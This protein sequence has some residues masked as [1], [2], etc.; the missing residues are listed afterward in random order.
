MKSIL[1]KYVVSL[2]LLGIIIS[3][4]YINNQ[5]QHEKTEFIEYPRKQDSIEFNAFLHT[6]CNDY[7]RLAL[8]QVYDL[9]NIISEKGLIDTIN[10]I[11]KQPSHFETESGNQFIIW[12]KTN[13]KIDVLYNSQDY[14]TSESL[15]K[16]S[17]FVDHHEK[18]F[19]D[20]EWYSHKNKRTYK[21][22][23]YIEKVFNL[24]KDNVHNTVYISSIFTLH[25]QNQDSILYS[26]IV[27]ILFY[28]TFMFLW[29]ILDIDTLLENQYLSLCIFSVVL[30]LKLVNLTT[31]HKYSM[32]VNDQEKMISHIDQIAGILAG[33][34]L[35]LSL[36][37]RAFLNSG[38]QKQIAKKLLLLYTIS[39]IFAIV[40]LTHI[41][42]DRTF[43]NLQFQYD[44]KTELLHL[45]SIFFIIS[46]LGI[47]IHY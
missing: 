18:G 13:K 12:T 30:L 34:T 21:K 41:N 37:F 11:H 6:K 9:K 42:I 27:S 29:Y 25:N 35:S 22:R 1:N 38:F 32:N 45:T 39:F 14:D 19:L 15:E 8:S 3:R 23:A 47:T 40:S 36:F 31:I 24:P 16:M 7:C 17:S 26:V 20:Y 4:V 43:E 10:I 28:L 2:C 5:K 44:V 46:V 33:L